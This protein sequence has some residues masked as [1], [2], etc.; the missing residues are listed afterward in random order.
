MAYVVAFQRRAMADVDATAAWLA[1]RS[2]AK[3]GRWRGGL[4]RSIEN[5]E[6]APNRYPAAAEAVDLGLDL[7]EMLFGRGRQV[8]RVLFTIEG[9]MVNIH[10]I[11]HAAQDRL[12]SKDI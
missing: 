12:T 8:H 9:Q 3:A 7:R 2:A 5:L 11:R 1:Q 10:R 4:L 6:T